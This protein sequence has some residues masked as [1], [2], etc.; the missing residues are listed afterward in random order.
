MICFF[1]EN[2]EK[3]RG[4]EEGLKRVSDIFFKKEKR[5]CKL[6]VKIPVQ[7]NVKCFLQQA[8]LFTIS[9]QT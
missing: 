9:R 5:E 1:S 4:F 7:E 6:S 3:Y 2:F 8:S